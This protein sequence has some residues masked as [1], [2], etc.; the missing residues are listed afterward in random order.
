MIREYLTC[1][2]MVELVTEYLEGA[3]PPRERAIF[4]AHLAVC[5]GCTAYFEQMRAT[6]RMTGHLT[7]ESIEPEARDTLLDVFR[8]WKRARA[9][10]S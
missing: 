1:R 10:N 3:M 4:E 7:E 2:E 5:P 8:N 6:I 9:G